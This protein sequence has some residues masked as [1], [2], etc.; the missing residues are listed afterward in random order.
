MLEVGMFQFYQNPRGNKMEKLLTENELAALLVISVLTIRRNRST[1]P[2]RLPPHVK[3]GASVRY[4][5][6]T[7]LRWLEEHEV[8]GETACT[9]NTTSKTESSQSTGRRRG[10]PSKT[11]IVQAKNAGK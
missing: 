6:T 3:V 5:L 9:Q 2:H 10:R 4:R 11:E 1:A 8:G 7:V